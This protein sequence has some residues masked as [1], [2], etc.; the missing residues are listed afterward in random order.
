MEY[1]I[2]SLTDPRSMQVFYVGQ[3]TNPKARLGTHIAVSKIKGKDG[4]SQ[5]VKNRITEIIQ[6]G[7][8]PSMAILEKTPD[9]AREIHWI[10]HCIFIGLPL[11][12]KQ[13]TVIKTKEE[14]CALQRKSAAKHRAKRLAETGFTKGTSRR[15]FSRPTRTEGSTVH[16]PGC[17]CG[18]CK[19]G[20]TNF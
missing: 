10:Q 13:F 14:R 9:K 2:Y 6:A 8:L 5:A 3:T 7:F 11:L 12:N 17:A 19:M 16:S 18:F 15:K 20:D 1:Y 4:D